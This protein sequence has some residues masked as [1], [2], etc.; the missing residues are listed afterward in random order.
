[1]APRPAGREL[2]LMQQQELTQKVEE[3]KSMQA[4]LATRTEKAEMELAILE[5]KKR[6]EEEVH[7]QRMAEMRAR[8]TEEEELHFVKLIEAGMSRGDIVKMRRHLRSSTDVET[9]TN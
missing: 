2:R 9:Q 3:S 8:R 4:L 6:Q 7:Q 1:M 5:Q